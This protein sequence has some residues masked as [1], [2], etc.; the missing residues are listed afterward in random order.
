M[1]PFYFL[2]LF[3]TSVCFAQITPPIELQSYYNG[4]DFSKNSL[5][6]FDDLAVQTIEKHSPF[7]TYTERHNYLYD[8]DED[9]LNIS[10]VILVYSGES[11]NENEYE[12]GSNPYNPQTFNTEHIYPRSLLDNSNAEADLHIL[13][14]CDISINSSRGNDPFAAGSGSYSS[15]GSAWYPGDDWRGDVARIIM[16]ANLRY[17][18]PFTDVGTLNLFLQWNVIDQVSLLEDQRNTIIS[19]AQGNRNPFIDNPYLATLIWGGNTAENRWNT[20]SNSQ[21]SSLDY[22]MFPN[23]VSGIYLNIK[24]N[25]VLKVGVYDVLGKLI[26]SSKLDSN[27]SKIDVSQ[28]KKGLYLIKLDSDKGSITKKLIKQ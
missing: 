3:F 17:N 13:R 27:N 14:T 19:G 16:Y 24:T 8:A 26:M 4:V 1:K 22:N 21:F 25:Q 2:F 20:L 10:K 15:T 12:S 11:R 7:L 9:P 6:L 5:D 28:L 23:P 18:E